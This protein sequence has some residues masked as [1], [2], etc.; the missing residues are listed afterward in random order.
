[1]GDDKNR[2][3]VPAWDG[4]GASWQEYVEDVKRFVAAIP[5]EKR[6]HAAKIK[7][8]REKRD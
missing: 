1:M 6:K 2:D 3:K 8:S 4:N 5:T 7:E